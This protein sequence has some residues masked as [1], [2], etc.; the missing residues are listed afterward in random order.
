MGHK[1]VKEATK[2]NA[3][4]P[5][6]LRTLLKLEHCMMY[7]YGGIPRFAVPDLAASHT[8]SVSNK[9]IPYLLYSALITLLLQ[10]WYQLFK[11]D[12][13]FNWERQ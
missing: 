4:L 3:P 12:A 10:Q 11:C 8:D 5:T 13:G 6:L 2:N 1:M 7:Q 9:I